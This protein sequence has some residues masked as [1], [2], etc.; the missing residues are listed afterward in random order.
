M[1][2]E[3]WAQGIEG[4]VQTV[5]QVGAALGVGALWKWPR[6]SR[7]AITAERM[8]SGLWMFFGDAWKHFEDLGGNG[9]PAAI[10]WLDAWAYCREV[11]DS[12]TC[13]LL[14]SGPSKEE[15]WNAFLQNFQSRQFLRAAR[16]ERN[17]R[18]WPPS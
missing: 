17:L 11:D 1:A 12:G 6:A 4:V 8:R 2:V 7:A 5:A 3:G 14:S 18:N 9:S 16:C 13:G 10:A 15:V